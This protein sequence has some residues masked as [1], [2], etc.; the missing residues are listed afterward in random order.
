MQPVRKS[1]SRLA[2][3]PITTT[4]SEPT[5]HEICIGNLIKV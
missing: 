5:L 2:Q 4:G 3:N 1:K